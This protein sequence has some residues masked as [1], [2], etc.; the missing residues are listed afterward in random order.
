MGY[1]FANGVHPDQAFHELVKLIFCKIFDEE[2]SEGALS[3]VVHVRER[4]S[5]SGQRRLV[6]KR[7]DPLFEKVKRKYPFIFDSGDRINLAPRVTAYIVSELQGYS[8]AETDTDVK[9]SAYEKLV[10][11]NLRSDHGEYFTPRNVCRMAVEMVMALYKPTELTQLTVIDCCCGTGGFLVVWLNMLYER[12]LEQEKRRGRSFPEVHARERVRSTCQNHLFGLDIVSFLVRTC[13]MNMVLHGDGSSNVFEAN[14]LKSP[15]EWADE[16]RQRIPFGK[17]DVV[18]TNPPFGGKG[19]RIDDMHIL[20]Q[21]ELP[22]WRRNNTAM[23]FNIE[24]LFVERALHFLK[25]GGHLAIILPNGILNNPSDRDIRSWLL[26]RAKLIATVEL[27]KTTF[28][29]S[30]GVPNSSLIIV[31]KLREDDMKNAD[32]GILN[33]DYEIFCAVPRTSGFVGKGR[34]YK[35][36]WV[37]HP[38]GRLLLDDDGNKI[39]DDEI[40]TVAE[41]FVSWF[42]SRKM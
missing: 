19:A 13:Q 21:Y 9:G 16:V 14:A 17:A 26:H 27:P 22:I 40:G 37:K 4:K 36:L 42:A 33:Q 38:D 20:S 6:E 18:I 28:N 3:F 30:G 5:E 1:I 15:G 7:L 24:R 39:K 35:P 2:E 31:Q 10:G 41:Q 23:S 11:A 25:P 29:A 12:I 34:K 32:R 8:L